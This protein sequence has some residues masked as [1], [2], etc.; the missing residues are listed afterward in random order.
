MHVKKHCGTFGKFLTI[1]IGKEE[2][3]MKYN[4][5]KRN[6][7]SSDSNTEAPVKASVPDNNLSVEAQDEK[8]E[9]TS[10]NNDN[11]EEDYL[12]G[13]S[14]VD[15]LQKS[16]YSKSINAVEE[17][18]S[19][20]RQAK[21]YNINLGTSQGNEDKKDPFEYVNN[22]IKELQ[23]FSFN[24]GFAGEQSCGK[25]TIINSLIGFPLMPTCKKV[26]TATI[27]RMMYSKHY[28]VTV[29]DDDEN[30]A[31]FEYNCEIPTDSSGKSKFL[32]NFEMLKQYCIKASRIL[33]LE[34][35]RYF[36]DKDIFDEMIDPSE[37]D[38]TPTDPMQVMFLIL[39][40]FSVY[41][42]Q[43]ESNPSKEKSDL[44]QDRK[45][46]FGKLGINTKVVN[47]SVTVK[48]DF[49][50]L[51]SGMIITDLPGLGSL[52]E[53]V[54]INGRNIKSHDDIT[55]E[56]IAS[57][58]AMVFAI[59]PKLQRS[60]YLA[61]Q[62]LMST[63]RVKESIR[64]NDFIIPVVNYS[65]LIQGELDRE[66]IYNGFI[67]GLGKVGANKTKDSIFGYSAI[68]GEY[69]FDNVPFERT[70]FYQMNQA[71]YRSLISALILTMPEEQANETAIAS[72][73]KQL[74]DNFN[75]AGILELENFFRTDYIDKG[76]ISK[77]EEI[78][79]GIENTIKSVETEIKKQ[80]ENIET[81]IEF[82]G[83]LNDEIID[84]FQNALLTPITER[85]TRETDNAKEL[86]K[87]LTKN[88]EAQFEDVQQEYAD[89]F[90]EAL[91]DYKTE[92]LAICSKFNLKL[93]SFKAKIT[94]EGCHNWKN[95]LLLESKINEFP[96][97]VV[98]INKKYVKIINDISKALEKRYDDAL[99]D[100]GALESGIHKSLDDFLENS[101]ADLSP[102]VYN[103]VSETTKSFENYVTDQL[104]ILSKTV[105]EQKGKENA[106]KDN[107]FKWIVEEND[108]VVSA[109]QGMISN[110]VNDVKTKGW[111]FSDREFINVEQLQSFINCVNI[112]TEEADELK[113]KIESGIS[114]QIRKSFRPWIQESTILVQNMYIDLSNKVRND[115]DDLKKVIASSGAEKEVKR[116]HL[117]E[118]ESSVNA[119]DKEYSESLKN[120]KITISE[121]N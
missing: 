66:T 4:K 60:G 90:N 73:K 13:D 80:L 39:V 94:P 86:N 56:A 18:A 103:A 105:I 76:K 93:F 102:E 87:V 25:S 45:R 84:K 77:S 49:K 100:L 30:K 17:L 42:G 9:D 52:A 61:V 36:T 85:I 89:S 34:N 54:V 23:T 75:T 107:I 5:E 57:T 118:L 37:L 104:N 62:E 33:V 11:N 68:Y 22:K 96:F 115:I 40:L 116:T 121:Y 114:S 120:E 113:Q 16:V 32:E 110:K 3:N 19:I 74:E 53:G 27:V 101:K 63:A 69:R 78:I 50:L 10:L 21:N 2:E 83:I 26:T 81:S 28:S 31:I 7:N 119:I 38:M 8:T 12:C 95:Y 1:I 91:T 15:M 112:T 35:L 111:F 47:F 98:K 6:F 106:I 43:D 29:F 24:V 92:L 48:G 55:K 109:Y 70:L 82:E 20:E 58:D 64:Q 44:M 41:V 46:I 14:D 59:T 72:L 108:E 88:A 51:K 65:D 99:N 79:T 117:T 71:T 67:E 97:S